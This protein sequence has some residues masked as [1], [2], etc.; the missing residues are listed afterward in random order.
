MNSVSTLERV[1]RIDWAASPNAAHS[2][3]SSLKFCCFVGGMVATV[4]TV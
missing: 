4:P 3:S 1:V 2:D